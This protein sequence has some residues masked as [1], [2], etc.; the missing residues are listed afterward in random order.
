[1]TEELEKR[2]K[3]LQKE[4]RAIEKARKQF[5]DDFARMIVGKTFKFS[6][7]PE[8]PIYMRVKSAK[9][10]RTATLSMEIDGVSFYIYD[11]GTFGGVEHIVTYDIY[12]YLDADDVFAWFLPIT[13][14]E[15]ESKFAI[16]QKINDMV[17]QSDVVVKKA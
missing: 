10:T 13:E 7:Y 11:D 2:H 9:R 16:W 15:F 3:E 4:V 5:T 1:M 17:K 12:R 14:E 8:H 6:G